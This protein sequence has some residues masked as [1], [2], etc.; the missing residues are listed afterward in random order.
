[1]TTFA[2]D[3]YYNVRNQNVGEVGANPIIVA[4]PAGRYNGR[5]CKAYQSPKARQHAIDELLRQVKRMQE[6][7]ERGFDPRY[8]FV[9]LDYHAPGQPKQ[10]LCFAGPDT[11]T[12]R[13]LL[14]GDVSVIDLPK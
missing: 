3:T 11:E 1:M 13:R 9:A 7:H 8:T 2:S 4:R 14:A 5:W 6:C 10:S 12:W